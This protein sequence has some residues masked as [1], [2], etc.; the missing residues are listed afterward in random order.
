MLRHLALV[1]GGC[2][3]GASL[4][5]QEPTSSPPV[6]EEQAPDPLC[7]EVHFDQR[8]TLPTAAPRMALEPTL[9][10]PADPRVIFFDPYF[11]PTHYNF[12]PLPYGYPP[13][14]MGFFYGAF[15]SPYYNQYYGPG[16]Y[17]GF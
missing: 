14:D 10:P 2:L 1:V 12:R 16:E 15:A 3:I 5:A 4:A 9:P 13:T 8:P 11:Y 6:I 17:Y 7:P